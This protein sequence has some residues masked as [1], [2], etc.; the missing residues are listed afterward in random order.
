MP[1]TFWTC[2]VAVAAITGV[3]FLAGFFS[4]DAILALS[5]ERNGAVFAVLALTAVLTA[6]YMVRLWKIVFFGAPRSD[7]VSH[8]HEGGFSITSPLVLLAVLSVVG[9]YWRAYPRGFA[10]VFSLIP[11]AEG[12]T[13][14]VILATS[15]AVLAAGAGAALGFYRTDGTDAL[16]ARFPS[17]YGMLT[18]LRTSFDT[19]YEYYVAKVQQRFAMVLNFIDIVGL[20]GV[21]VRGLA[22]AT[23][24]VGFGLRSLHTG[25][26][27]NYVYWFLGGVVILW[28][29]AAGV[30]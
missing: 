4:K 23:E 10:G 22:G 5:Y 18:L 28:A 26:L 11:E 9:G 13:H 3:P 30:L 2:T 7:A 15:L 1:L 8:A 12:A 16:Q 17:V 24:I 21:V 14:A 20:A 19:A 27:N 6:F 25:R 29:Y